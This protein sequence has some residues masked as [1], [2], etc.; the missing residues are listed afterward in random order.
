MESLD[1]REVV[2]RSF[3]E[4]LARQRN[5]TLPGD[6]M[7]AETPV[8]KGKKGVPAK[9]APEPPKP[10]APVLPPPRLVKT[11]KP[12]AA[13]PA[14]VDAEPVHEEPP[15]AV[16]EAPHVEVSQPHAPVT[17]AAP[18]EAPAPAVAAIE[19]PAEAVEAPIAAAAERIAAARFM[20]YGTSTYPDAT[21]TP[22]RMSVPA[23]CTKFCTVEELVNVIQPIFRALLKSSTA[24]L[25]APS[26]I[27]VR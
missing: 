18:P 4:R 7:F 2:A 27:T 8:V 12:A 20:V 19:P 6:D 14:P 25:A 10:A 15:A 3:V 24:C 17:V 23:T 1:H 13:A 21:F 22:R 9:K 26:G 5:I 11:V 16:A